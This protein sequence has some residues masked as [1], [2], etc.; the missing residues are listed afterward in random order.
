VTVNGESRGGRNLDFT[1]RYEMGEGT[2]CPC[3]HT[4]CKHTVAG[5]DTLQYCWGQLRCGRSVVLNPSIPGRVCPTICRHKVLQAAGYGAVVLTDVTCLDA[6]AFVTCI[7]HRRQDS[8]LSL[9]TGSVLVLSTLYTAAANTWQQ[10]YSQVQK[11]NFT[12]VI[13]KYMRIR[14]AYSNCTAIL[15]H[16]FNSCGYRTYW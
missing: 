13:R 8:F 4:R 14:L 1:S 5:L 16:R 3:A 9:V 10:D 15:A 2:P 6:V 12:H 7:A 11:L